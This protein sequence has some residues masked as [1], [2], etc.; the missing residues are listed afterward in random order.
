MKKA[1]KLITVIIGNKPEIAD[2][3]KVIYEIL[4]K[5]MDVLL[6]S[7]IYKFQ[8][9][10]QIAQIFADLGCVVSDYETGHVKEGDIF[11]PCVRCRIQW[12]SRFA[13]NQ[14]FEKEVENV[15]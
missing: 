11:V 8:T 4:E 13:F 3:I 12:T 7:S 10:K 2:Y 9:L 15:E 5:G 14:E 1:N 6:S